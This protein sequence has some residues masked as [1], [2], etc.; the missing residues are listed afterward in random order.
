VKEYLSRKGVKF[1]E[2]DVTHDREKA[3]EMIQKSGQLG[4]PVIIVDDQVV[5]G[6]NQVKLDALLA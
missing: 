2:Y 4:V 6:F 1:T 5:V 3:K